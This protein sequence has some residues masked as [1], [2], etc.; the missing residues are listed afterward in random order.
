MILVTLYSVTSLLRAM[1]L[2]T[3]VLMSAS[4]LH[5]SALLRILRSPVLFF[6]SNPSGRINTRFSKDLVVMDMMM[7]P[8]LNFVAMGVFR[9]LSVMISVVMV[10]YYIIFPIFVSVCF[11]ILIMKK[12]M[13]ILNET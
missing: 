7:V 2:M 9:T 1:I 6:D 11:M 4:G 13:H 5:N 12:A 3:L 10:N 8:I